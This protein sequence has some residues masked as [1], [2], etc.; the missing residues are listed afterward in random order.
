MLV[1]LM[2]FIAGFIGFFTTP[3]ADPL[4]LIAA[5]IG[6][7]CITYSVHNSYKGDERNNA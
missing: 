5:G 3:V 6:G 2:L 7:W 4:Y 1:G